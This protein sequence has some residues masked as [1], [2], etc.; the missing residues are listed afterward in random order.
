M[1][2]IFVS[3]PAQLA[4]ALRTVQAGD[5]LVLED[6]DYGILSLTADFDAPV[7]LTSRTPLGASFGKITLTGA[8]NWQFDGLTLTD[9]FS[10][11]SRSAGIT[12]TNCTIDGTF[13]LKDVSRI[14]VENNDIDGTLHAMILNS[15]SDFQIRNNLIHHAQE[16]LLR[17]TGNS[18]DG[19][20]ENNRFW[21]MHPE[22]Y[23]PLG[24]DYNHA[25]AI[26]M[27]GAN[28]MTPHDIVIRGNHIWDDPATGAPTVTPQGIFLSD[29]AAGGYRNILIEENLINVR[30]ANS[31]YING[32]QENVVIRHNTLIPAEGDGGAIIRLASKAG[33][34]NA[35][36]TVTGNVFKLLMDET[37]GSEIGE[38]FIYGRAADLTALF[39]G[40]GRLPEDFLPPRPSLIPAEFGALTSR[41]IHVADRAGLLAALDDARDGDRIVLADGDYGRLEI[42]GRFDFQVTLVAET[43]HG[44]RFTAVTL[45]RASNLALEDIAVTGGVTATG[46]C[47]HI[48]LAGSRVDG[49]LQIRDASHITLEGNDID[50]RTHAI[51]MSSVSD[52]VIRDNVI[53]DADVSL[54]RIAGDSARGLI[55]GNVYHDLHGTALA[56][57]VMVQVLAAGGATPQDITIRGN[58]LFDDP[59]TGRPI[60][61]GIVF[62]RPADPEGYANILIADNLIRVGGTSAIAL[63]EGRSNVVIRDNTLMAGPEGGGGT[64][65]LGGQDNS[66]TR[67]EGNVMKRLDDR[68]RLEGGAAEAEGNHIY[69]RGADLSALFA[70]DGSHW[71]DFRP[72]A[73][74]IA[75]GS[76]GVPE[77]TGDFFGPDSAVAAMLAEPSPAY[78]ALLPA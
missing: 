45:T 15:V 43:A 16:D 48:L 58:Y 26:Q 22:D 61:Q 38:N 28:G 52:F 66:G 34:D 12:V 74:T 35:G 33:Y 69:G 3:G 39:S 29:P 54:T 31:I 65:R 56:Q 8:T 71:S 41:D 51:V 21:D 77:G 72:A 49:T 42:S 13:Y 7:T 25:D 20:V 11:I 6:G 24:G 63:S 76:F 37:R 78:Y 18:F 59:A 55:E 32:G 57:G 70:G 14:V 47:H 5:V 17:M 23:R 75:A 60:S 67:V 53:R 64:L 62:G 4:A 9:G 68:S 1:A 50:G 19:L 44:A 10:A 30:S 27:F 2:T 40:S 73:E 36:T 46:G